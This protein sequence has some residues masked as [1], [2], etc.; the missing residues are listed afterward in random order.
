DEA[1][2]AGLVADIGVLAL[3]QAVGEKYVEM[4]LKQPHGPL[5]VAAE[6]ELLGVSHAQGGSRLL[7]RWGLPGSVLSAVSGHPEPDVGGELLAI[8]VHAGW[9]MPEALWPP[10]PPDVTAARMYLHEEC[11]YSLDDFIDLALRCRGDIDESA[12]AF[13]I[14]MGKTLDCQQLID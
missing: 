11:R 6:V 1:Y 12:K 10:N 13:G 5:L 14:T 7:E 8:A 2:A 3:A 4:Y 9:F